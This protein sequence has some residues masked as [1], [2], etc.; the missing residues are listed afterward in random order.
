MK[1]LF[2]VVLLLAMAGCDGNAPDEDPG[3]ALAQSKG[4]AGCHS[5][6]GSKSVGP[7]W[8]GIYG[9]RVELDDGTVVIADDAYLHE[10]M[11]VPSAKTVKGFPKGL[12]ETVIKPNSLNEKEVDQLLA[13][14]KSLK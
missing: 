7:T 14:I 11:L 2:L 9:S 10:S 12:M 3:Q 1:V 6:D 8:Q 13:Y 4:C 5:T